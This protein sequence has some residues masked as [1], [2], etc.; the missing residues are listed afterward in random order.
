MLYCH[1]LLCFDR[2]TEYV[3]R[4]EEVVEDVKVKYWCVTVA[5]F[6][7]ERVEQVKK[8]RTYIDVST[9]CWGL[10]CEAHKLS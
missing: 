10:K 1:I 2:Y 3:T 5:N 8:N 6:R 4:V 9:L 7:C